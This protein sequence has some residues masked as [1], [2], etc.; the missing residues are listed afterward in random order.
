MTIM[1]KK[2]YQEK[3][4]SDYDFFTAEDTKSA[5]LTIYYNVALDAV[6]KIKKRMEGWPRSR[7][8]AFWA[9]YLWK[10][11]LFKKNSNGYELSARNEWMI[12][13][14]LNKL[15]EIRNFH[16]H[17]WHDNNA[18]AFDEELKDYVQQKYEEAK[19][20][21]YVDYPGAV[22]DYEQLEKQPKMKK[23]AHFKFVKERGKHFITPEGRVFFLSFFLTTGQMSQLLQQRSGSKRSDMPL[24]KVKRLLYAYYC[25]RDG[26]SLDDFNHEEHFIDTIDLNEKSD[27]L[28]ARTAY[29][30]MSYLYDYPWYWGNRKEMPLYNKQGEVIRNVE[31]LK[32]FVECNNKLLP[33]LQFQLIERKVEFNGLINTDKEQEEHIKHQEDKHR[34][35]TIAFT[36]DA[37]IGHI[38]HIDFDTLHRLVLLQMLYNSSQ[39]E[40]TPLEILQEALK[41]Q[42]ANRERIAGILKTPPAR[43]S[44]EELGYLLDKKNQHLRGGRRLTELGIGYFEALE[45]GLP[46]K[47]R[48]ALLLANFLRNRKSE[49]IDIPVQKLNHKEIAPFDPEPIHVYQ[50]DILLGTTQKFRAGNRFMFY[51]ARYL[52]DFAGDHWYLGVE[53]FDLEKKDEDARTESLLKIKSYLKASELMAANDYRLTLENDH[54][55]LALLKNKNGKSNHERFYQFAVGPQA[56]RYLM[57][58]LINHKEDFSNKLHQFLQTLTKDLQSIHEQGSFQEGYAYKL[59]E[60]PFVLSFLQNNTGNIEKLKQSVIARIDYILNKWKESLANKQYMSRSEKN[61][62]IMD[63]YR[64]F[65]WPKGNDGHPRFFRAS[66][67]NEMSVCHYS[68]HKKES[69]NDND[70]QGRYKPLKS[71]F[72]YLFEDLFQLYERKPP[73]PREI[74]RLVQQANSLDELMELVIENRTAN[75]QGRKN[76]ILKWSMP[77]QQQKKELPAICRMLGISV[78]AGILQEQ[79]R[80]K[81]KAKQQRT[82]TVQPFAIHP[83][84]VLKYFFPEVCIEDKEA[85]Y[86]TN[87]EGRVIKKLPVVPV[88]ANIRKNRGWREKLVNEFYDISKVESLYPS[89]LHKKQKE[90]LTG[91]MNT[92]CTEDIL[93][94]W[95]CNEYLNNNRYTQTMGEFVKKQRSTG[96]KYVGEFH[97][98]EVEIPLKEGSSNPIYMK[99]LMHQLDDLMF[100]VQ[101]SRLGQAANHFLKRCDDEKEMWEEDLQNLVQNQLGGAGLPDGSHGK[102]IPFKLLIAELELVRRTGQELAKY[103]LEFE[104][105]VLRTALKQREGNKEAFHQWLKEEYKRSEYSKKFPVYFFNFDNI[106]RLAKA[107][108]IMLDESLVSMMSEYRNVTFHNDVPKNGSFSW[109]TRIGQPLRKALQI[110]K[111]LHAK[112]DRS[113]YV[114]VE[115]P[116]N[117]NDQS[118]ML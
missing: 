32:D 4:K 7:Q 104:K 81:L 97:K 70:R 54:V 62:L 1:I 103:I 113:M 46:E 96:R 90:A 77:V 71:K 47:S 68:L 74:T 55:Y 50:Q 39:Q 69:K 34:I 75:L 63:A 65:E 115:N 82:M 64:L 10:A 88:F 15:E 78:P 102:P 27:I 29:K 48:D 35:G 51:A 26:A 33:G 101:Q 111:D 83:M 22:L 30:L 41:N 44:E 80:M 118:N 60:R 95:M 56:M 92:T 66:E 109:L 59:I 89:N 12:D 110:E 91:L 73:L 87:G 86:H 37:I 11:H 117:T 16:S 57:A 58:Y 72:D 31:Q 38:F 20:A 116:S 112:K 100:A 79:E 14:L 85:E 106:L 25:H 93:L 28:K 114:I 17:I 52:M 43:R 23:F 3:E 108:G 45:K 13:L 8:Y 40:Q 107:V 99:I 84:L 61:R 5:D 105:Q 21:L 36:S 76:D 18:L 53:K 9:E 19:A 49:F 42:A 98:L 67:F 94:W 2:A 24:F 6:E